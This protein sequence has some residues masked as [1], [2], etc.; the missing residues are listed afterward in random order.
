MQFYNSGLVERMYSFCVV[1]LEVT[2]EV[3][4]H[5]WPSSNGK[6]ASISILDSIQG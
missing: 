2:S 4:G 3:R 6:E 5:Q 1:G